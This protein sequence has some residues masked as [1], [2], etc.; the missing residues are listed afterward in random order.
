[1]TKPAAGTAFPEMT[2]PLLDGGEITI[3]GVRDRHTLLVVYRGKHCPRCKRYLDKLQSLLP[4]WDAAGVDV[5]AVSADPAMKA[6][7]DLED[8]GWTFPIAYD[9]S[10]DQMRTMG[11]YVSEP[12]SPT[13]TD[14]PF[15]EPAVFCIRPD[16]VTQIVCLSNGP[17]ARP[18]LDELID[19]VKFN[20]A[21][22][23]PARGTA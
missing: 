3:G 6:H 16:G 19:G 10:E 7:A 18:D 1:M 2:F 9:L 21:N 8:F 14:R 11:L 5:V 4:A 20:I 23:R 12:L 15:A 22:N 17:A 13:E